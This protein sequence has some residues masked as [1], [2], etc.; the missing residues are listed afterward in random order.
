M[1]FHRFFVA[2]LFVLFVYLGT[3]RLPRSLTDQAISFTYNG[4]SG[5][6]RSNLTALAYFNDTI[7]LGDFHGALLLWEYNSKK[8]TLIFK[9]IDRT[10]APVLP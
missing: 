6:L 10:I 3:L 9:A 5:I 1:L 7:V 8:E 2:T 4:I